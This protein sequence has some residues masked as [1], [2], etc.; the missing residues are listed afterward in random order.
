MINKVPTSMMSEGIHTTCKLFYSSDTNIVHLESLFGKVSTS[1]QERDPCDK[2]GKLIIADIVKP[3][4][5]INEAYIC[6]D[7]YNLEMYKQAYTSTDSKN[8]C[9]FYDK[10]HIRV[11]NPEITINGFKYSISEKI[12][13][14]YPDFLSLYQKCI[15]DSTPSLGG[16]FTA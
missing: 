1:K 13:L 3:K 8:I 2:C 4:I 5:A 15:E 12:F 10:S 7:C 11:F 14:P 16:D 9:S 6:D